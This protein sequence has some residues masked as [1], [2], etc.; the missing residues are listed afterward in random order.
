MCAQPSSDF[1]LYWTLKVAVSDCLSV[2]HLE[3]AEGAKVIKGRCILKWGCHIFSLGEGRR[4]GK[5][6]GSIE[7]FIAH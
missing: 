4:G 7:N 1:R 3:L 5:E 2:G 6:F